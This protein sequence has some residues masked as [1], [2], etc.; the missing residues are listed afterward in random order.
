MIYAYHIDSSFM[1]NYDNIIQEGGEKDDIEIDLDILKN[2]N[3]YEIFLQL[4]NVIVNDKNEETKNKIKLIKSNLEVYK[5]YL[6]LNS[7]KNRDQNIFIREE[8]TE[9]KEEAA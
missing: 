7:I 5:F 1:V 2:V 8:V 9:D 4:F 6:Y 3:N